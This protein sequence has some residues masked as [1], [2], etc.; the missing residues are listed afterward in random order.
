MWNFAE[1][2][3]CGSVLTEVV[4]NSSNYVYTRKTSGV[5]CLSNRNIA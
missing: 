3:E 5:Q 2:D 1:L 4:E